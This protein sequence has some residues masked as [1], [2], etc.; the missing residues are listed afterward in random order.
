MKKKI[1][2][3]LLVFGLVIGVAGGPSAFAFPSTPMVGGPLVFEYNDWETLV[4]DV[5]ILGRLDTVGEGLDGVFDLDALTDGASKT[6]YSSAEG[7]EVTG[8]LFGATLAAFISWTDADA[9]GNPEAF[10]VTWNVNNSYM[11]AYWDPNDDFD[12]TLGPGDGV[13]GVNDAFDTATNGT[14]LVLLDFKV[15]FASMSN[16]LDSPNEEDWNIH[17]WGYA[18]L[19]LAPDAN[20][21]QAQ[22]DAF[23]WNKAEYWVSGHYPFGG[24]DYD[25]FFQNDIFADGTVQFTDH[26]TVQ[27]GQIPWDYYSTDDVRGIGAVPEP[28]TMLLL[29]CGLLGLAG[30]GRK[31]FIKKG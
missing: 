15:L 8:H 24:T 30:L 16:P 7:G 27:S 2:L 23:K 20:Y 26:A 9:D 14:P 13:G 17:N 10:A 29:G 3:G 21:T 11:E 22:I 4:G 6:F 25:F 18:D 5:G 1:L 28:A 31:K 19:L 12:Y